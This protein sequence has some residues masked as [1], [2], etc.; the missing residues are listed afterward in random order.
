MKRI[1]VIIASVVSLLV[2]S[3]DKFGFDEME[4]GTWEIVDGPAAS[5]PT[6]LYFR[7][8]HVT[9][10]YA[11]SKVYPL[12]NG[13]WDY[14]IWDIAGEK[15]LE[16][17]RITFDSYGDEDEESHYFDLRMNSDEDVMTLGYSSLLHSDWSYD[18]RKI[19]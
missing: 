1:G 4:N 18:F 5:H 2:S 9:I 3:C 7:G 16:I 15:T 6:T 12:Q 17:S 13:R 10:E 19:Q 14:T 8:E 11:N